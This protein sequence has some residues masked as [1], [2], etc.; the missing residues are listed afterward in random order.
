MCLEDENTRVS[1]YL[2][3]G[4]IFS[5]QHFNIPLLEI[6]Y[7]SQENAFWPSKLRIDNSQ[8]FNAQSWVVTAHIHH[9]YQLDTYV[10]AYL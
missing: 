4:S 7:N 9:I 2:T 1:H 10:N 3:S 6:I 5:N 8:F